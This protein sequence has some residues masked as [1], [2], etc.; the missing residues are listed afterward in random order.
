MKFL[1]AKDSHRSPLTNFLWHAM[2]VMNY[3]C[4][5]GPITY[6]IAETEE[7]YTFH[8][9]WETTLVKAQTIQEYIELL[10]GTGRPVPGKTEWRAAIANRIKALLGYSSQFRVGFTAVEGTALAKARMEAEVKFSSL[11][12]APHIPRLYKDGPQRQVS[13]FDLFEYQWLERNHLSMEFVLG[14]RY[15]LTLRMSVPGKQV[16]LSM[17]DRTYAH[18]NLVRFLQAIRNIIH[19]VDEKVP[20]VNVASMRTTRY[21]Y[22]EYEEHTFSEE[23]DDEDD[24]PWSS[25]AEVLHTRYVH[26]REDGTHCSMDLR[27]IHG[28]GRRFNVLV[29]ENANLPIEDDWF[30]RSCGVYLQHAS[31]QPQPTRKQLEAPVLLAFTADDHDLRNAVNEA[32]PLLLEH[33][34]PGKYKETYG[35]DPP[36]DLL[37]RI[38][39]RYATLNR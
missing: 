9:D 36:Y 15:E 21:Y 31:W 24:L 29:R 1:R 3:T 28:W 13:I 38:D 25:M 30:Y 17:G 37:G 7:G 22:D 16:V 33:F 14:D 18:R 11:V 8:M 27:N 10:K 39:Q 32:V 6:T 26:Y 19:S 5:P 12:S 2:G 34:P 20:L 23:V 35:E 4:K